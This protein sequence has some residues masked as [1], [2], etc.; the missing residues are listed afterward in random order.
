MVTYLGNRAPTR[1]ASKIYKKSREWTDSRKTDE[2]LEELSHRY[3]RVRGRVRKLRK[4]VK[5]VNTLVDTLATHSE[6][7]TIREG[8]KVLSQGV[9]IL[10]TK[11]ET[12]VS[13]VTTMRQQMVTMEKHMGIMQ[14]RMDA[15]ELHTETMEKRVETM[16]ISRPTGVLRTAL[17]RL[18]VLLALVLDPDGNKGVSPDVTY[19]Y[20][21]D[22][23]VKIPLD[24]LG[25]PFGED[26]IPE[27]DP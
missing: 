21:S 16:K 23:S 11:N 4:K 15:M 9:H 6:M 2:K 12:L 24:Y 22:P 17:E 20:L 10:R 18:S 7:D 14:Q 5:D 19:G 3:T 1:M 27:E 26:V 25:I 13:E 8:H